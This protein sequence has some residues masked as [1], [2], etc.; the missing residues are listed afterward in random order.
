MTASTVERQKI[1]YS[2]QVAEHTLR[3]WNSIPFV[4][5]MAGKGSTAKLHGPG[6]ENVPE[7]S[8]PSNSQ[9]KLNRHNFRGK[10]RY[11][12]D[13]QSAPSQK[14]EKINEKS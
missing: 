14:L 4:Q 6:Q 10:V 1:L 3:Q 13:Q 12:L 8:D 7:S 5:L 2:Q 11:I 9:S